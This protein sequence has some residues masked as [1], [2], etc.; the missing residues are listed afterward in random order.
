MQTKHIICVSIHI[1]IECGIGRDKNVLAPSN[2]IYRSKAVLLLRILFVIYVS[3]SSCLHDSA[4][5]P[6]AFSLTCWEKA[7][8]LALLCVLCVC[9]FPIK[10][11]GSAVV[12]L[13]PG[14]Y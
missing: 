2:V 5:L 9:Y 11:L 6:V 10:C 3:C 1:R 7:D 14:F 12:F 13:R 8:H 4:V